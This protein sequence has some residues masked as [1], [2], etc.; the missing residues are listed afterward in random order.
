MTLLAPAAAY[1]GHMHVNSRA[2]WGGAKQVMT[3]A[4]YYKL[5]NVKEGVTVDSLANAFD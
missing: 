5:R 4:V 3:A 2:M 1:R